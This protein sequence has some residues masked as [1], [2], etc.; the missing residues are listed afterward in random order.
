MA[1]IV[2]AATPFRIEYKA[3]E[4]CDFIEQQGCFPLHP[5]LALP[6][7]RYNYDRFSKEDIYRVCFSIVDFSE[8]LWIF[9][10][11][12]GSFSEWSRA[13]EQE[14]PTRSFVKRFD[15]DWKEWSQKDK[16]QTK[17]KEILEEVLRLS[18]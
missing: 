2:Y 11:G 8:E 13:K 15:P 14:K 9:G 6:Y 5:L 1:K 17:Y 4:I 18:E 16:Y 7:K 10:I 3:E 12:S